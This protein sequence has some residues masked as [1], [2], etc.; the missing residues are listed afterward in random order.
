MRA[1]A[2]NTQGLGVGMGRV[3][4]RI[5]HCLGCESCQTFL[6]VAQWGL[7]LIIPNISKF[8]LPNM[9]SEGVRVMVCTPFFICCER[10]FLS[11]FAFIRIGS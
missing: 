3:P 7:Q 10:I 5:S 8:S 2:R 9:R 1:K 11:L 6:K 4:L